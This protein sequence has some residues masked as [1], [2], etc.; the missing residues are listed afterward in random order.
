MSNDVLSVEEYKEILPPDQFKSL[1]DTFATYD[2]DNEGSI[3]AQHLGL[4][5][6]ASGQ[7]ATDAEIAQLL[8]EVDEDGNGTVELE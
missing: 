6:L 2:K 5:M 1:C 7:R 8:A 3:G 4:M